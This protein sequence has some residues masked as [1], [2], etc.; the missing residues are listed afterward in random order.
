MKKVLQIIMFVL[1]LLLAYLVYS[2]MFSKP[3]FYEE[4]IEGFPVAFIKE[5]SDYRSAERVRNDVY[6]RLLEKGF[7][8]ERGFGLF[9][10]SPLGGK[11]EDITY[12]AGMI[13]TEEQF[14]LMMHED[15]FIDFTM[16][17][18]G[19]SVVAS[20]AYKTHLSSPFA[21][22]KVYSRL[23]KYLAEKKLQRGAVI[24]IYDL[25]KNEILFI[26]STQIVLPLSPRESA[27]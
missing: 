18:P 21:T 13:L 26:S 20:F 24:E 1:I 27:D 12:Y 4:H 14:E 8:T 16:L 3:I 10:E 19:D 11:I 22:I 17:Y 7:Q 15:T 6:L 5:T 9:L 2:G 25:Q 23:Q